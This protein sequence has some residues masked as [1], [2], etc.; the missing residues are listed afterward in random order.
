MQFKSKFSKYPGEHY[1]QL[2]S[3]FLLAA[4]WVHWLYVEQVWHLA[5]HIFLQFSIV[6]PVHPLDRQSAE[7]D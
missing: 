7:Q 4:H 2:L 3:V 6:G 1:S 5:W